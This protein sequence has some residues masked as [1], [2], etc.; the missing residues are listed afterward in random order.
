MK[1]IFLMAIVALAICSSCT[2]NQLVKKF[3]GSATMD[4]PSGQKL[5]NVDWD[6]SE[7]MWYLTRPMTSSDTAKTYTFK[8]SSNYGI[9]QG[10]Y[11]IVEHK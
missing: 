3:G 5:I 10:T 11:T 4:L 8:E 9:V 2:K 7:H 6:K 1:R